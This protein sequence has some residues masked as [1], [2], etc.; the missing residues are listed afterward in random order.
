MDINCQQICKFHGERLLTEV[1]IFQKVLGGYF[2]LKHPVQSDYI[3][4][5]VLRWPQNENASDYLGEKVKS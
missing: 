1:K 5:N 4:N 2:C 3:V